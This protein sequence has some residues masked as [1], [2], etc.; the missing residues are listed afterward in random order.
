[1]YVAIC[2]CSSCRQTDVCSQKNTHTHTGRERLLD[3]AVIDRW[4]LLALNE[5][6]ERWTDRGGIMREEAEI[7]NTPVLSDSLCAPL[8][9]LYQVFLHLFCSLIH[10]FI[11]FRFFWPVYIIMEQRRAGV[12]REKLILISS[13]RK[14]IYWFSVS[15]PGPNSLLLIK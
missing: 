5:Y 10:L 9:S 6:T 2:L 13:E 15:C 4:H 7:S 1:M 12:K 14:V 11:A 3:S 8:S